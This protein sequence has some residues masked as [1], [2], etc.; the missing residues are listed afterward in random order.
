MDWPVTSFSGRHLSCQAIV[1]S[2]F[3]VLLNHSVGSITEAAA[4][5]S[6]PRLFGD[7]IVDKTGFL[8]NLD[9]CRRATVVLMLLFCYPVSDCSIG[10]IASFVERYWVIVEYG[11]AVV[12]LIC[13]WSFPYPLIIGLMLGSVGW[14]VNPNFEWKRWRE[15]VVLWTTI[16]LIGLTGLL[17]LEILFRESSPSRAVGIEEAFTR[18]IPNLIR[19]TVDPTFTFE[20]S[21]NKSSLQALSAQLMARNL[22]TRDLVIT[23]SKLPAKPAD[24][25]LPVNAL[26]DDLYFYYR[27]NRVVG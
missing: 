6:L 16:A 21:A 4:V 10:A 13:F 27:A 22:I 11:L 1:A 26:P 18:E 24:V 17:V 25:P 20:P 23:T 15:T 2:Y 8:K 12:T 7:W 19:G 14:L 5:A 9:H 3:H